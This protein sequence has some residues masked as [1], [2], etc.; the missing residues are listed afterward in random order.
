[1]VVHDPATR[2]KLKD[3]VDGIEVV[4][5]SVVDGEFNN[6]GA[7]VS[8]DPSAF[9]Q[10]LKVGL[11]VPFGEKLDLLMTDFLNSFITAFINF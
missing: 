2:R 7:R 6:D 1:M 3:Y 8:V 4:S 5:V 10:V 9:L 11:V